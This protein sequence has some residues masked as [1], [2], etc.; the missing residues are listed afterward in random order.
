M[1]EALRPVLPL[2]LAAPETGKSYNFHS[3]SAPTTDPQPDP[4]PSR[5]RAFRA[6]TKSTRL[7]SCLRFHTSSSCNLAGSGWPQSGVVTRCPARLPARTPLGDPRRR[8]PTARA[9]PRIGLPP[10]T[11]SAPRAHRSFVARDTE[12]H[13]RK[14]VVPLSKSKDKPVRIYVP[15][16]VQPNSLRLLT[17]R[18]EAGPT[19]TP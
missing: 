2:P 4:Y 15:V 11:C 7:P 1:C 19:A 12:T 10:P 17:A 16:L 6:L 5:L 8:P 9:P 18:R 14:P 13:A 3:P